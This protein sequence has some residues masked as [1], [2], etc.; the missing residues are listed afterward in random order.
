[1][2]T[3]PPP[4]IHTAQDTTS[5]TTRI[6]YLAGDGRVHEERVTIYLADVIRRAGLAVD[7][8]TAADIAG[9]A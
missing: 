8:P 6:A 3:T 9:R 7:L 1:M 2:T 5:V 4:M